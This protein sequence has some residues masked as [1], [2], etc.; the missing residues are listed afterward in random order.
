MCE[1]LIITLPV[2][3]VDVARAEYN[4]FSDLLTYL[5]NYVTL[6]QWHTDP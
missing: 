4:I 6:V 1:L 5:E 3:S 2:G